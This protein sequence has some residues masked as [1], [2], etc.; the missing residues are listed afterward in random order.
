MKKEYPECVRVVLLV[1]I[2][3]KCMLCVC[4]CLYG[5]DN[6]LHEIKWIDVAMENDRHTHLNDI[7]HTHTHS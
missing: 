5:C 7:T 2:G 6:I 3:I 1:E 4:V